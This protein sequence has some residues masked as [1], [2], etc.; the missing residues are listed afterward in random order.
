MKTTITIIASLLIMGCSCSSP[1]M[2]S[3][4]NTLNNG[5][6]LHSGVGL[7][8]I[9]EFQDSAM[10]IMPIFSIYG[11]I[12]DTIVYHSD[13]FT[14]TQTVRGFFRYFYP[15]YDLVYL[16]VDSVD[17]VNGRYYLDKKKHYVVH[18]STTT[19]FSWN[20]FLQTVL[21]EPNDNQELYTTPEQKTLNSSTKKGEALVYSC[22]SVI[23]DWIHVETD[24]ICV[25]SQIPF[26][27]QGWIKWKEGNV[28]VIKI[29]LNC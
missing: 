15:E 19:F 17:E 5:L 11:K 27:R 6:E 13:F 22:D 3:T 1:R 21:I 25:P 7:L 20:D 26:F 28:M 18:D 10:H 12:V 16:N 2:G 9:N 24:T 14:V 23:G 8:K 29:Y 4:Q